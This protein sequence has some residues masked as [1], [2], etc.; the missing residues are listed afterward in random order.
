ML[1]LDH[2]S[3]ESFAFE[4]PSDKCLH[5]DDHSNYVF[6]NCEFFPSP[7]HLEDFYVWSNSF[8][9]I[10]KFITFTQNRFWAKNKI[11]NFLIIVNKK[12]KRLKSLKFIFIMNILKQEIYCNQ[13]IKFIGISTEHSNRVLQR[14]LN[15]PELI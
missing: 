2:Y 13:H 8:N 9:F 15:M 11:Y 12:N 3:L 14:R 1:Y 10:V 7:E 6:G 5:D 4:P